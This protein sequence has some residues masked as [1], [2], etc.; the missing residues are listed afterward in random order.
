[1]KQKI[2]WLNAIWDAETICTPQG[3]PYAHQLY[4]YPVAPG[5]SRL[6]NWV[7]L[8]PILTL[9]LV[10]IEDSKSALETDPS[11]SLNVTLTP[12]D[13][14]QTVQVTYATVEGSALAD[15]HYV[16]T[17]GVLTF[18]PNETLQ[19]ITIPLVGSNIDDPV[20]FTVVLSNP[21][22]ANLGNAI[23]TIV[24]NPDAGSG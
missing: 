18:P 4:G 6:N 9:S 11:V 17:S 1:M 14:S 3:V 13:P 8:Q 22:S 16:P 12:A 5:S 19:V 20:E 15:V 7:P 23:A 21:Q 10:E 2:Q 24:I